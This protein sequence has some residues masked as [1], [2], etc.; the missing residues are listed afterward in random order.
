MNVKGTKDNTAIS[1][2]WDVVYNS[3]V[4]SKKQNRNDEF[5]NFAHSNL[6]TNWLVLFGL[7][8]MDLVFGFFVT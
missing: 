4:E 7:Y 3:E 5:T 2:H 8:G 6:N 1:R